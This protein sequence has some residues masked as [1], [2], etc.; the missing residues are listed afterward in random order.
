MKL[1]N[2]KTRRKDYG[3]TIVELL[4]VIV[5]IGI[6]AAIT[7]VSYTG[8]TTRANTSSNKQNA[9]N[10]LSAAN[11]V[12]ANTSAWP[13][14]DVAANTA[15]VKTNLSA[16]D[17][18]LSLPSA[19]VVSTTA[20]AAGANLIYSVKSTTGVCVGYW[21]YATSTATPGTAGVVW[22]FGGDATAGTNA[23]PSVCS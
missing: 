8:I 10:V 20:I 6:L 11:I 3:F 12:Y 15:T 5:V 13:I 19:V 9:S 21:D 7:I 1:T 23:T 17:A 18:K 4:V 14:S 22:S 2:I 16:S